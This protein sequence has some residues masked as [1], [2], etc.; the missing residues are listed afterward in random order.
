MKARIALILVVVL[1][2][3][4][5]L[6]GC[7]FSNTLSGKYIDK[8]NSSD[9]IEFKGHSFTAYVGGNPFPG[10]YT[11]DSNGKVTL[12]YNPLTNKG[13]FILYKNGN[14]LSSFTGESQLVKG[15]SGGGIPWWGWALIIL[16]GIG[17]ISE[18]VS[19]VYKKITKRDI[20]EDINKLGEKIDE[21]FNK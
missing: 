15:G 5:F 9:Y 4:I 17:L 14:T 20:E 6:S 7:F 21:K 10:T 12:T 18:I 11:I 2:C 1:F 13:S 3:S 16:G 8:S 19:S